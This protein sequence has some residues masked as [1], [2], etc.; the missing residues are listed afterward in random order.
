VFCCD[1]KY[2]PYA[3]L[4]IH[5]LVRN[6]PVR[7]YD[8]CIT[9]MDALTMPHV[10]EQHD[11]RMCQIG[12]GA[13]FDEVPKPHKLSMTAYLRLVLAEALGNDYVKILY[14]DCDVFVVGDALGEVFKL[15]LHG[16][17]VGA[18]MDSV[19]WKYPRRE[20]SD[21]TLLGIKGPFFNSGVLLIHSREF[22]SQEIRSSVL[23]IVVAASG[24]LKQLDQP[25]LNAALQDNWVELHPAWNWQWAIVRPMFGT[26]IDLQ[27]V[28]FTSRVK[29]WS[30]PL[31]KIPVEYRMIAQRFFAKYYPELEVAISAPATKLSKNAVIFR[32]TKHVTRSFNFVNGY[33]R[34]GGD[35]TKVVLPK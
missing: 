4:A 25:V 15:N 33:N 22:V 34:H 31:G 12:V 32:L 6:N 5:T 14:L 9:S 16:R 27:V 3:A 7:D 19:K 18:C 11:I 17:P 8:I 35:I 26:Y 29:P 24:K 13:T 23:N 30:D 1:E 21:Q 28:H 20:T 2:L 10:L